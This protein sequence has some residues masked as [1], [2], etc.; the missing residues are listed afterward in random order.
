MEEFE[1]GAAFEASVLTSVAQVAAGLD[2]AAECV[3]IAERDGV[4]IGSVFLRRVNDAMA[5]LSMLHVESQARG[6]GIGRRLIAEALAF[7]T[8]SGYGTVR[9]ELLDVQKTARALVHAAGFRHNGSATDV[10]NGKALE[11]QVWV[12]TSEGAARV[13]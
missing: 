12:H 1:L 4:A 2:T 9:L 5:E 7:A 11:R 3:W 10:A 13:P 6:I 8:R